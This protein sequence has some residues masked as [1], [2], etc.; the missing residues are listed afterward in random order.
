MKQYLFLFCLCF[1]FSAT[2][3]SANPSDITWTDDVALNPVLANTNVG[4]NRAYYACVIFDSEANKWRAWFDASSGK[5]I[6]YAESTDVEGKTWTTTTLCS[7]FYS[8]KQSKPFVIQ[9][10]PNQFRMWYTSDNRA[11]GYL[12]SS[13][14]SSDGITWQDDDWVVGIAEPDPTQYG[15]T[16]RI[17]VEQLE[18]GSF[19]GYV[20]CEEPE[21]EE[22][23]GEPGQKLLYRYTSPDGMDWTWT[24]YTGVN[25]AEGMG[26]MEFSSVVKHPDRENVWYAWG[27]A[28]NASGPIYSFVSTDDGLTYTLDENP[29]LGIGEIGTESYN[30]DRNYHASATYQGNGNWVLFRTV[31]EPKTTARATGVETLPSTAVNHWELF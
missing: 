26:G 31:A 18:D 11:G 30:A 14:V 7:G 29:V 4:D 1:A 24:G 2:V 16:E 17:A 21:I 3:A 6:A 25:D 19:V 10:S 15:P 5:D 20:R 27:T 12:I 22:A 9:V 23:P 28:A 13:C 8:G